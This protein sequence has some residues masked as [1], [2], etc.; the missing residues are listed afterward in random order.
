LTEY[1]SKYLILSIILF[2]LLSTVLAVLCVDFKL[3][4]S[5]RKLYFEINVCQYILFVFNFL[6]FLF[7]VIINTKSI[8][9]S[10][11]RNIIISIVIYFF[12]LINI[13][14]AF[15]IYF[16]KSNLINM[17]LSIFN[18]IFTIL[19]YPLAILAILAIYLN[20]NVWN[21][22]FVDMFIWIVLFCIILTNNVIFTIL[23]RFIKYKNDNKNIILTLYYLQS[24]NVSISLM[25]L[26]L[27]MFFGLTM[28]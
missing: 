21:L 5:V 6:C 14:F 28:V 27:S 4:G 23:F 15:D 24:N 9:K 19:I 10:V 17:G 13:I 7:L 18:P 1:Y 22:L 26:I 8:E 25:V 12:L 20:I 16:M 2:S 3:H 11:K